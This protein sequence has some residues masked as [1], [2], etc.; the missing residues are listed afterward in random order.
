LYCF[1]AFHKYM[2]NNLVSLVLEIKRVARTIHVSILSTAIIMAIMAKEVWDFIDHKGKNMAVEF[3]WN[4]FFD[5][6]R[7]E[8]A[9][10]EIT[11]LLKK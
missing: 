7:I 10:V 11:R 1:L 4:G 3:T 2:Q 6:I 5:E 8:V 9:H